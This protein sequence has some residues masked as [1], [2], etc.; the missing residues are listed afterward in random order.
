MT[1][2]ITLLLVLILG[3][4]LLFGQQ[5]LALAAPHGQNST[6]TPAAEAEH[7]EETDTHSAEPALAAL[8][9]RIDAL[10]AQV[11]ALTANH[12]AEHGAA[13]SAN[14]VTTAI[15]LLDNAG[16]HDLDERLNGEGTIA[17]GDSGNVAS[18]AR[19]LA[20]VTWPDALSTAAM[21]TT[22]VLNDLAA[23]L[24]DDDL[25]TAAALATTAHDVGHNLSH[26]A[27]HWLGELADG[28]TA[29][30][31]AGQT[32][33]VTS[34]IYLLDNAGLHDL[35]VRLNETQ[36]L[37][38]A[39]A[40]KIERVA[41]LLSTVDWP[42]PLATSAISVTTVLDELAAALAD[43]DLE[44]AAALATAAHDTGHDLSH[45]AEHWLSE[46]LGTHEHGD[47]ASDDHATDDHATDDHAT[48]D[49]DHATDDHDHADEDGD[50]HSESTGG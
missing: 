13:G 1:T 35:D 50:D 16:L 11:A 48:D 12:D 17:A 32:F 2:R 26:A 20:A 19:L 29:H 24:A 10:E 5:P 31:S 25:E 39:D 8:A 27:E 42:E 46:A 3:S 34:A 6:P 30:D 44:T 15:Y 38:A 7:E 45:A 37:Q 4:V 41:R 36:E 33:R 14:E 28:G 49:D 22:V 23:A 47:E 43:D 9:A 40:G 21:S 18:V